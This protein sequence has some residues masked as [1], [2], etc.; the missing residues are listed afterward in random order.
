M[1]IICGIFISISQQS[2]R[3]M[4]ALEANYS[5]LKYHLCKDKTHSRLDVAARSELKIM[6][7]FLFLFTKLIII[8]IILNQIL[9]HEE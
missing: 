1:R 8:V 9:E 2:N 4:M 7:V 3:L 6:M 5:L